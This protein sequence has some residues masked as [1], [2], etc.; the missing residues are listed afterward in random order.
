MLT[1]LMIFVLVYVWGFVCVCVCVPTVRPGSH[2][3][4]E[5]AG[6]MS[7]DSL[8]RGRDPQTEYTTGTDTAYSQTMSIAQG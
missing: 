3:N 7:S 8:S 4:D 2:V 1:K 6:S 5:Y